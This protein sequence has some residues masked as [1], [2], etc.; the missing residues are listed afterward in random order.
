MAQAIPRP[1]SAL[2]NSRIGFNQSLLRP[3][4]GTKGRKGVFSKR[5]SRNMF[6]TSSLLDENSVSGVWASK[7]Q[8]RAGHNRRGLQAEKNML[9]LTR[10][11]PSSLIMPPKF[12]VGDS[13]HKKDSP[14]I[15]G[16][17]ICDLSLFQVLY[18]KEDEKEDEKMRWLIRWEQGAA[19]V[20]ASYMRGK[21]LRLA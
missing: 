14:S 11:I 16:T 15:R 8:G 13:V 19:P 12:K 20:S 5:W 17:I 4:H 6:T 18:E 21:D 10:R 3:L 7:G 2:R 9:V 1:S